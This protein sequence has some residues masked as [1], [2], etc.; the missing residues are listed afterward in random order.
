MTTKREDVTSACNVQQ[1]LVSYMGQPEMRSAN[2]KPLTAMEMLANALLWI[3]GTL[4]A[5]NPD[6]AKDSW[7]IFAM[8]LAGQVLWGISAF[9]IRKWTLLAS[10]VFFALLNIWGILVRI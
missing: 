5:I 6:M 2:N 3:S 7:L 1:V 10:S 9:I 4:L 8:L